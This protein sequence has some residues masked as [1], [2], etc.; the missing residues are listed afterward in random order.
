MTEAN[1]SVGNAGSADMLAARRVVLVLLNQILIRR[2]PMDQAME[3]N[4]D[5]SALP[6]RDR[7][8]ARMILATT[9]RRLGQIDDVIARATERGD[10]PEP[11]SLHNLLRLGATQILFMNVPDH[12]AVDTS[13]HLA[14]IS[15]MTRQKGLV[16]AVLRRVVRDGPEW[17]TLQDPVR[18]N[19]PEWLLQT[20]IADYGLRQAAE[21]SE[22]SM[23]EAPVDITL[24]DPSSA[25]HW[26]G[27]LDARILPTG[28][29]R[30]S[31]GGSVTDLPGFHDG[32]WWVQDASAAIPV[33]LFGDV[34]G[35]HI[36][37]LCAAPGGKTAQLVAAGA[38]VTAVDRS[39]RRLDRLRD[40]MR[41]LRLEDRIDIEIADAMQWSPR[42]PVDMI[43]LDAPCS[44]TGTL[45]RHPDAMRLKIPADIGRLCET[46]ARMLDNAAK[47]LSPGGLL[48]YC[49]CSLQKAEGEDQI[50][51]FL[52]RHK[53]FS[54]V[55]V[56]ADELGEFSDIL[57][58][59]GYVRVLPS[60]LSDKGGMDGFFVVRLIR[61]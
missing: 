29:L 44:A 40:N 11:P 20:W 47:V 57:S 38:H 32:M 56:R 50:K 59:E 46:Q 34:A 36:V 25:A 30:L 41:R 15:G 54:I 18:A 48:V 23:T 26:A 51:H 43:L 60:Y 27:V 17:L 12:A 2:T 9:L 24:K 52:A 7:A 1:P 28:S 42:K 14:D 39:S 10:P 8:F 5:F 4:Q 61:Q 22:S 37:D 33:R 3:D 53:D 45:R 35:K 49:T 21:I 31:S 55:P 16:N 13:V 19:I 58:D 6:S